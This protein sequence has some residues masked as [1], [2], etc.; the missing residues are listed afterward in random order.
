MTA[1][2]VLKLYRL[3]LMVAMIATPVAAFAQG[4]GAT[5]TDLHRYPLPTRRT[6]VRFRGSTAL[7]SGTR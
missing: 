4:T 7:T 1:L 2:H 3:V 6:G 5:P